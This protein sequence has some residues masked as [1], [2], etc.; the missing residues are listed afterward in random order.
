MLDLILM[1]QFLWHY[2]IGATNPI[3]APAPS[4]WLKGLMTDFMWLKWGI[5]DYWLSEITESY[6]RVNR[7]SICSI[8]PIKL[9]PLVIHGRRL[10]DIAFQC[11]LE[12]P[13][14]WPQMD[15]LAMS[16]PATS[17]K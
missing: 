1:M 7:M 5:R 13:L 11:N 10:L 15:C 2:L 4:L 17:L 6:F 16:F 3:M 9:E 14:S 12:I 8:L